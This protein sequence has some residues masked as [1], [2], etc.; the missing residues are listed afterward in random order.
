MVKGKYTQHSTTNKNYFLKLTEETNMG[1]SEANEKIK[2][3]IENGKD[4]ISILKEMEN[5]QDWKYLKTEERV[6]L[7]KINNIFGPKWK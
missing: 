3:L 4:R 2:K 1:Y 5:D 6:S 7:Q